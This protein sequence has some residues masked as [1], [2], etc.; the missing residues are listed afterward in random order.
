MPLVEMQNF[1]ND[2]VIDS[3]HLG[4][5]RPTPTPSNNHVGG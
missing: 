2:L 5:A 4:R 1:Q 3:P